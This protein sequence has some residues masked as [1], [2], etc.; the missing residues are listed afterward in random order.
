[1]S[2]VRSWTLNLST[3][4][5]TGRIPIDIGNLE[6]LET[7][8][9]SSNNL[10]RLLPPSMTALTM[11]NYLNLSYNV[12]SGKITM[13]NQFLTLNDPSIYEGNVGL[14]GIPLLELWLG[15]EKQPQSPHDGGGNSESED[16][17]NDLEYLKLILSI[18]VGFFAGFWGVCGT[19]ILKKSWREAYYG[20][21]DRM[22]NKLTALVTCRTD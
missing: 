11:L 8:D 9:L 22:K 10:S 4:H 12:F 17:D 21:I 18:G 2:L 19:L 7:L 13:A 15:D 14:R 1:M 20:C 3:N 6:W 16:G 5:L